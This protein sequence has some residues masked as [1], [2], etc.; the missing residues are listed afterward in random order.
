MIII[1]GL[2][3]KIVT[4]NSFK[5]DCLLLQ[6]NTYNNIFIYLKFIHLKFT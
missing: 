3:C 5:H 1:Q 4:N 6:D 2:K